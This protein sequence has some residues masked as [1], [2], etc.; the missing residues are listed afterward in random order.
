MKLFNQ[1]LKHQNNKTQSSY[2][3]NKQA[4]FVHSHGPTLFP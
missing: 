4:G 3:L 2:T 1:I